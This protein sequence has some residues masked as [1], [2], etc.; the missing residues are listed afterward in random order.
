MT[1]ICRLDDLVDGGVRRFDIEGH[2]VAVV[3]LG[4]D[5]H[6]ID[7]TCSHAR[8]SLSQGEVWPLACTLECPKHGSAFSLTTGV[9]D[10]LPATAAVAVHQ[11]SIVD[12]V[13]H[14]EVTR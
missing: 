7:D 13:V 8:V 2:P 5:V 9:P 1:S 6:A 14:V 3:R 10:T 11:V 12:G 4:D